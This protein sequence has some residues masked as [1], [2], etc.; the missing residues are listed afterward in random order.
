MRSAK[1]EFYV[2]PEADPFWPHLEDQS[3]AWVGLMLRQGG[4]SGTALIPYSLAVAIRELGQ[5]N[6]SDA[7][8]PE[9]R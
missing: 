1:C 6:I 7:L 2:F 3:T 4:N 9:I 5:T 8:P